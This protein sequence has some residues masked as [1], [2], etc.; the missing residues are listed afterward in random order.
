MPQNPS[1]IIDPDGGSTGMASGNVTP[2]SQAISWDHGP[3]VPGP[4]PLDVKVYNADS[5]YFFIQFENTS[6]EWLNI[7][8]LGS[9]GSLPTVSSLAAIAVQDLDLL[10]GSS[11]KAKIH[12]TFYKGGL[13]DLTR[14]AEVNLALTGVSPT[15]IQTDKQNYN[16][17]YRRD[18]N[19]LS[20]ETTVNILNNTN[21]DTI[22]IEMDSTV[23][24]PGTL[25]TA[26]TLEENPAALLAT[27]PNLPTSGVMQVTAQLKRAGTVLGYFTVTVTVV[28]SN[29]ILTTPTQLDFQL[30]KDFAETKSQVLRIHNALNNAFTITGPAWLTFSATSGSASADITVTTANSTTLGLGTHAGNIEIAYAG[31]TLVVP[32]LITVVQFVNL[33]LQEYNFCLDTIILGA[34]RMNTDGFMMRISMEMSFITAT[35]LQNSTTSYL[36]PY[37]QDKISTDIGKKIQ[38]YFPVFSEPVFDE[39]NAVWIYEPATVKL[40]LEELDR[41]YVVLYSKSVSDLRFFAGKRPKLFPLFTDFPERRRFPAS[42][43]IFSYYT[44]LETGITFGGPYAKPGNA[45]SAMLVPNGDTLDQ[46]LILADLG[47]SFIPFPNPQRQTLVQWLNHNLVPEWMV[48]SGK[49]SLPSD[50]EHIADDFD[51]NAK[52]YETTERQKITINTG[53]VLKAESGLIAEIIKSKIVFLK[54]EGR[55][56]RTYCTSSKLV[57]EESETFLQEYELEF[58]IVK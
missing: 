39:V 20:G 6:V 44:R 11:Y 50:F 16:V 57:R 34:E 17:V 22:S 56:Y 25:T 19:A 51:E 36:M 5:V 4:Q 28:E 8:G 2:F 41:N 3:L 42:P 46:K 21:P 27:N 14:T 40:T 7:N 13:A 43:H 10:P 45:V 31:T 29:E 37:F 54:M 1:I 48:F 55:V 58:K 30:R 52:K 49:Y 38:S 12:V 18:T 9:S 53:W 35:G 23:F 47:L 15:A 33:P 32:V 26:F 24:K